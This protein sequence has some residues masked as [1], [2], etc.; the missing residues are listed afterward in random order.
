MRVKIFIEGGGDTRAQ[1]AKL[2]EGFAAFCE[3]ALGDLP[4]PQIVACGSR[5]QA[6]EDFVVGLKLQQEAFLM[7]LVDSED[8][9]EAAASEGFAPWEHL[10]KCDGWNKPHGAEDENA[11]L[12]APCMEGWFLTDKQALKSLYKQGF[13]EDAWPDAVNLEQRDK[14]FVFNALAKA[15]RGTTKGEY[16]EAKRTRMARKYSRC[17]I[18]PRYD[19]PLAT[20]TVSAPF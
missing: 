8:P 13:K 12:M 20:Q 16:I 17:W 19:N 11:H 3:K 10:K 18:R 5:N 7:L 4:R 1:Q 6:F 2:R 9:I 14:E 15:T